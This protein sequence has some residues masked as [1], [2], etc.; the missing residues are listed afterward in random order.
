VTVAL[1]HLA[2]IE[3]PRL[4]DTLRVLTKDH[5]VRL[6]AWQPG[7]DSELARELSLAI[8][9]EIAA[10]PPDLRAA[11]RGYAG[12]QL[13]IGL[14]FH[15]LVAAAAAGTRFVA[16]S[17]EPKLAAMARRMGQRAVPPY[18]SAAVWAD[19]IEGALAGAAP[20]RD[21]VRLEAE[22][23]RQS[24]LLLELLVNGGAVDD[25]ARV[26]ALPLSTGDGHW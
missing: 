1:S 12:D 15:S 20:S 22:R 21:A 18:A 8:D 11:A 19:A 4:V 2:G 26:P 23:A 7:R 5:D 25:P 10:P 9:A 6:E 14:R 3:L 24:M 13:V 16:V 17:H